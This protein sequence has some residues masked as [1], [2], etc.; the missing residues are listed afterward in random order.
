M[1]ATGCGAKVVGQEFDDSGSV[2]AQY[3]SRA[4]LGTWY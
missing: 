2:T 4:E 3:Q 1:M